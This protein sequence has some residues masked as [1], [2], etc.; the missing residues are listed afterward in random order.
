VPGPPMET[1]GGVSSAAVT[2]RRRLWWVGLAFIPS[3]LMLG[4]T[5]HVTTDIAPVPLLW[6]VPLALYLLTFVLVFARKPLLRHAWMVRCFPFVVVPVALMSVQSES[7]LGWLPIPAHTL[8]FFVVAMVC[9]GELAA[10]RP[11]TKHLTEFYLWLSVGGVLGGLFNAA[12]APVIFNTVFE[13]PLVIVLS[14]LVLARRS[15][16]VAKRWDRVL[17]FVLPLLA[18]LA[19][20]ALIVG[21]K[22]SGVAASGP[23]FVI[24]IG[25]PAIICVVLRK[26]ALRLALC[27]GAVMLSSAFCFK[28]RST[29]TL[30]VGR[31]FFGVK[32]IVAD[33]GD[34]FHM[35]VHGRTVHGI[36]RTDPRHRG[37]PMAYFHRS[38]PVGDVFKLLSGMKPS[39]HV[40]IVGLGAGSMACYAR[41]GQHFVFYEID[42][43]VERIAR[44]DRYF[45]FLADCRGTE[46]VIVGDG[47]LALAE[48]PDGYFGKIFLDAFS[49]DAVPTHLLTREAL[50]LYLDKLTDDGLLI[51]N[52]TNRYL[53]LEPALGA[54]AA[55][56]GLVGLVRH[57]Q[58]L[59]EG[60]RESGRLASSFAV[61]ARSPADMRWL[62]HDANW[63]DIA[64]EAKIKV[65]T[66]QYSNIFRLLSWGRAEEP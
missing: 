52:I 21:I 17:D 28:D 55:D 33:P 4:V 62:V 9:H 60:A 56:A 24:T 37:M 48:A 7:L 39:A 50:Q 23:P 14:C 44:D 27:L 12:V 29:N 64:H 16:G 49:S 6:V 5:T 41:P 34:D 66:D 3:S 40:A 58:A 30:Y 47:R 32:S 19:T 8:M 43:E 54:L 10:D 1:G 59:E 35:F 31:N 42:P 46:E 26:R 20:A 22:R 57:D 11:D 51:F 13:Y 15:R 65:W 38:G 61:L 53:D 18:G 2:A 25:V 36:Q 63:K 45:T